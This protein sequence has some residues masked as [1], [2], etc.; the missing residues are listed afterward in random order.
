[1]QHPFLQE[2]ESVQQL[3]LAGVSTFEFHQSFDAAS[4]M[5]ERSEET[6]INYRPERFFSRKSEERNPDHFQLTHIPLENGY[7]NV[8]F[9]R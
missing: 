3:F 9:T 7:K 2:K 6:C 1:M 8:N 5:S 4:C